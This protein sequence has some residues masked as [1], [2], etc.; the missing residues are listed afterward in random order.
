MENWGVEDYSFSLQEQAYAAFFA[1]AMVRLALPQEPVIHAEVR[2]YVARQRAIA[3]QC[4]LAINSDPSLKIKPKIAEALEIVGKYFDHQALLIESVNKNSPL[5][6]KGKGETPEGD[7]VRGQVR[8]LALETNT[9]FGS[10]L[11]GV[12]AKVASVALQDNITKK[13]VQNWCSDL[14]RT[15]V[16]AA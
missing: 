4:R 3:E 5:V 9:I 14:L 10:F 8:A 6:L 16:E 11:L 13:D 7:V 12:L 2:D 1:C 15:K